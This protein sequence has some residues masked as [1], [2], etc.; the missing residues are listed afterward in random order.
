MTGCNRLCIVLLS[1]LCLV[2]LVWS[3]SAVAC[4]T[5]Q[6]ETTCIENDDRTCGEDNTDPNLPYCDPLMNAG[7]SQTPNPNGGLCEVATD[8]A[9]ST[10][11]EGA[12]TELSVTLHSVNYN[13]FDITVEWTHP[14]KSIIRKGYQVVV[15]RENKWSGR[16]DKDIFCVN[17]TDARTLTISGYYHF[18]NSQSYR[19]LRVEVIPYPLPEDYSRITKR[20][21]LECTVPSSCGELGPTNCNPPRHSPL[22]NVRLQTYFYNIT[23]GTTNG[24]NGTTNGINEMNGTNVTAKRLYI[25]WDPATPFNHSYYRQPGFTYTFTYYIRLYYYVPTADGSEAIHEKYVYKVNSTATDTISISLLLLDTSL[26]YFKVRLSAHYPCAGIATPNN[27]DREAIGCGMAVVLPVPPPSVY[28]A[29]LAE[30]TLAEPTTMPS[31]TAPPTLPSNFSNFTDGPPDHTLAIAFAGSALMVLLVI[32]VITLITVLKCVHHCNRTSSKPSFYPPP[33]LPL[34]PSIPQRSWKALVVY[35]EKCDND[36]VQ[37]ILCNVVQAL[38]LTQGIQVSYSDDSELSHGCVV[39]KLEEKVKQADAV[40]IVCNEA[41]KKDWNEQKTARINAL[42]FLIM[43]KVGSGTIDSNKFAVVVLDNESDCIPSDFLTNMSKFNI[44][45][46]GPDQTE[47]M[48]HFVTNTPLYELAPVCTSPQS[49]I[50]MDLCSTSKEQYAMIDSPQPS[51]TETVST[52]LSTSCDSLG[53]DSSSSSM[54]SL[55]A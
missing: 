31:E 34:P 32:A 4:T 52:A 6:I 23:N 38:H 12:P 7:Y 15:V 42:R 9:T 48:I 49:N 39:S 36:E 40:L 51:S 5:N 27:D 3:V 2:Q 10:A 44:G 22:T 19:N 24:T 50:T 55:P 33:P 29:T 11:A 14:V 46:E 47:R 35:S 21:C 54:A 1:L 17:E 13:R 45:Q 25:Q 8:D 16:L 18:S 30:P 43:S 26:V 37:Y 28:T 53:E 20:G 41:F